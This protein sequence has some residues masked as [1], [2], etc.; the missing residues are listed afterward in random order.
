MRNAILLSA[1]LV[2]AALV[3][4]QGMAGQVMVQSGTAIYGVPGN[5]AL[6][7]APLVSTPSVSL[8]SAPLQV[9]ASNATGE[10]VAGATNSTLS[11][12][13]AENGGGYA[14]SYEGSSPETEGSIETAQ[15]LPS[16]LN[17]GAA[18]FEGNQSVAMLMAQAHTSKAAGSNARL[19]T[20]QDVEQAGGNAEQAHGASRQYTNQDAEQAAERV[21]QNAGTVKLNGKVEQVQ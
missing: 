18:E 8:Q 11:L 7:F 15:S 14:F 6:P 12:P 2:S 19:Y 10:N 5:Y 21:N 13:A 1:L 17:L 9:G 16:K 4:T 20:N 3:F